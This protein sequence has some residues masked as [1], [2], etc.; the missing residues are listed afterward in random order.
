MKNSEIPKRKKNDLSIQH[1]SFAAV[2]LCLPSRALVTT[3]PSAKPTSFTFLTP[4]QEHPQPWVPLLEMIKNGVQKISGNLLLAF[5]GAKVVCCSLE[6][7]VH[8][9]HAQTDAKQKDKQLL[10]QESSKSVT[11]VPPQHALQLRPAQED[12]R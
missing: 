4:A 9:P 8:Y 6:H 2:N 12:V 11:K 7:C 1:H 3:E 5:L 10:Q